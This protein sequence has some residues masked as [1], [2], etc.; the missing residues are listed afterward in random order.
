MPL[1]YALYRTER[2]AVGTLRDGQDRSSPRRSYALSRGWRS[3]TDGRDGHQAGAARVSRARW[4]RV[5]SLGGTPWRGCHPDA[6]AAAPTGHRPHRVCVFPRRCRVGCRPHRVRVRDYRAKDFMGPPARRGPSWT[7]SHCAF[8]PGPYKPLEVPPPSVLPRR[9]AGSFGTHEPTI[10][11]D[12]SEAP[13]RRSSARALD[14]VSP[15]GRG[16]VWGQD[17]KGRWGSDDAL[18]PPLAISPTSLIAKAAL[19]PDQVLDHRIACRDPGAPRLPSTEGTLA[20]GPP[21]RHRRAAQ[22][23][24]RLLQAEQV[25]E[26]QSHGPIVRRLAAE[27]RRRTPSRGAVG[28]RSPRGSAETRDRTLH[29]LTR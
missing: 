7:R 3:V 17:Q 6:A 8:A 28:R 19:V 4:P 23:L 5:Q 22:D 20:G 9:D 1:G 24:G 25:L 18:L 13:S 27:V 21:E 2:A 10:A 15:S 26:L 11:A 12:G 29:V 14:P 16:T